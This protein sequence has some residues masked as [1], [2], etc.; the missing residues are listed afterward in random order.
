VIANKISDSS[1]FVFGAKKLF[2]FEVSSLTV[3]GVVDTVTKTR[4]T[5]EQGAGI[6]ITVNVDHIV[7]LRKNREFAA[8]YAN[9]D[10]IT[11]DGFP[12]YYM[13]R[14]RGVRLR[15]RVTGADITD[16]LLRESDAIRAHRLFFVADSEDTVNGLKKW[17]QTLELPPEILAFFVPPF[18]FERDPALCTEIARRISLHQTSILLMG[19]GAP[20]SEIFL[21]TYRHLIPPCWSLCVGISLRIQAGLLRRA[22]AFVRQLNLEWFWRLCCEPRRLT[23]RYVVGAAL[24]GYL[25][26]REL[27]H[28]NSA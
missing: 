27:L 26:V 7:K 13:A 11:C 24:F 21:H 6:V 14:L 20:K 17:A 12:V 4:R 19:V 22:P 9:A 1:A 28:P 10:I 15:G 25:A 2:G 16:L 8:A 3:K 5:A 23:R 18:G